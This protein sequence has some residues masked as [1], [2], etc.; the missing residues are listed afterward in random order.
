MPMAFHVRPVATKDGRT[1][2][3]VSIDQH[4][5]AGA[6]RLVTEPPARPALPDGYGFGAE[7]GGLR[8]VHGSVELGADAADTTGHARR[9]PEGRP[10]GAHRPGTTA[11]R[12]VG[13]P[14][15]LGPE[16]HRAASG[17]RATPRLRL[18]PD[19]A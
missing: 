6:P 16:S 10:V 15:R 1:V 18:V 4:G 8:A 13:T 19:P 3:R 11:P 14:V 2:Y 17:T 12:R 9:R 5:I 7:R